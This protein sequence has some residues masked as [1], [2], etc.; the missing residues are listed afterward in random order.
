VNIKDA[1]MDIRIGI[2]RETHRMSPQGEIS[3]LP[4]PGS[5]QPPLF[6]KDFAESQLEIVTRPHTSIPALIKELDALILEAQEACK[7]EVFWPYSMPPAL[8]PESE[9]AIARLGADKKGQDG[10]LYRRGLAS[11]YGKARQ[12]ICGVHVNISIGCA[13]ALLA[14][15]TAPLLPHELND[16]RSLDALYLRL[17]RHLFNDLRHLVLLTGASPVSGGL[18]SE[19]N[20]AAVSYRNSRHGYARSEFRPYLDL[21]SLE[22]YVAGVRRGLDTESTPFQTLQA[23][24]ELND[25]RTQQLNTRVFQQEKEFY[26]PI[27][28]KRTPRGGESGLDALVRDGVE[29]LELRFLDVDPFSPLGV[30]EETLNVLHLFIL[31]ALMTPSNNTTLKALEDALD[32]TEL[33]ALTAPSTLTQPTLDQR[34]SR[35]LLKQARQRLEA[36]HPLA[37]KLD[38]NSATHYVSAL[39]DFIGRTTDAS[40]L[41]SARLLHD[42]VA[43]RASWT[44]FGMD[45]ARLLGKGES[46]AMDYAT[47]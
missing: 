34:Q 18:T 26:A 41:P 11:R 6:A 23:F 31:D 46:H 15:N 29:Y 45:T 20:S 42:F 33:A 4:Q 36:L 37:R 17:A 25:V 7:P 47:I 28:F 21:A 5:L 9:I 19:W 24:D 38:M 2:E 39:N 27:R 13:L 40:S 1:W 10:E 22:R 16:G 44:E 30:S 3:R 43:S 35:P 32:A 14:E 12:M 8:P